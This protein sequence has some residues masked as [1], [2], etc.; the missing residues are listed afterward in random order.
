[1]IL[2][3]IAFLSMSCFPS[4]TFIQWQYREYLHFVQFAS[5]Y[6]LMCLKGYKYGFIICIGL[7]LLNETIQHFTGRSFEWKD[8]GM[9]LTGLMIVAIWFKVVI[10][11]R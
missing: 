1:M 7:V 5:V 9:E 2:L 6:A 11:W 10:L 3:I 4:D 8:I